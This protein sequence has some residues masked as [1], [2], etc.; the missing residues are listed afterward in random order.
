MRSNAERFGGRK[1]G[2]ETGR[3][4]GVEVVGLREDGGG[5][6]HEALPHVHG[7]GRHAPALGVGQRIGQQDLRRL[8]GAGFAGFEDTAFVGVA[9]HRQVL[10]PVLEAFFI[11]GVMRHTLIGVTSG[12]STGVGAC[13]H[14]MH[15]TWSQA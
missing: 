5:G 13:H 6:S 8:H 12:Q 2:I 1:R 9:E 15:L 11:E 7:D 4:V 10:V 3:T 14:L